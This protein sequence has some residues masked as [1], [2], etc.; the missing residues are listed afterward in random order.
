MLPFGGELSGDRFD[1][2]STCDERRKI[3]P[4]GFADGTAV[5]S[6]RVTLAIRAIASKDQAGFDEAGEVAPQGRSGHA[7]RSERKLGIGGKNDK[8][9]FPGQ[10]G[11]GIKAQQRVEHR[12]RPI[13]YADDGLG[14]A[15]PAKQFPLVDRPLRLGAAGGDLA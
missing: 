5:D 7:M 9:A 12:Q 1:F 10:F 13:G 6:P 8:A 3:E 15:E 14:F 2:G 4:E 11:A